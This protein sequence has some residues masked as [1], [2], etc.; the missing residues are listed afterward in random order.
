[1]SST[2]AWARAICAKAS[3]A[4]DQGVSPHLLTAAVAEHHAA[5]VLHYD[6]DFEHI[7]AVTGQEQRWVVPRGRCRDTVPVTRVDHRDMD[8]LSRVW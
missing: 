1:V 3:Q 2:Q 4:A 6:A 8:P 5:I 7:A